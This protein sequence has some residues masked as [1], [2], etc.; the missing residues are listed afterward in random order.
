VIAPFV[1]DV[2]DATLTDL[3]ER[4][5]RTR[6]PNEID[7]MAWEQGTPLASLRALVEYWL[8]AYDW[9]AQEA[10]LNSF[11]NFVADVYG[12]RIHFLHVRSR[13]TDATPLLLAHGWPGSI[14]EFLDTVG[15]FVDPPDP[16]DAFSLVI[17]SLPGYAFSAPTT[18]RGWNPR[19]IAEAFGVLM[20]ELGYEHYGVQGGD[21]G[22][23]IVCN[24]ADL[25]PERVVGLHV[26]FLTV[27]P[28]KG[29]EPPEVSPVRQRFDTSG[30]G[31]QQ[32]QSTKP[33]T[34]GYLLDDSPAGLAGWIVEKFREWSD[35]DGDPENV[36]TKDQLLTNI[37]LYWLNTAATS[38]ARLY[39]EMRQSGAQAV[40][41]AKVTVPTGVANFPAEMGRCERAHAERRYNIVHWTEHARGGHFAAMEQPEA[42][43]QD[44]RAFFRGLAL[45]STA[46]SA[47]QSRPPGA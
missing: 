8:D 14:V 36:F 28:P 42:F 5:A 23:M 33:Q 4:L 34:I 43:V 27:P 12:Q 13:H 7:G 37:M 1:I 29:V 11:D 24:M 31:Y 30:A 18:E 19:R 39:W 15:P 32:I 6:F 2:P 25:F 41:H 26:N 44:V 47:R 40:P 20:E 17:P 21:W 3:R 9:R 38:S 35:C 22:S 16:A 10:M 46:V 45:P